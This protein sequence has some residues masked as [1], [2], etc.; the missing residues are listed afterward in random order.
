MVVIVIAVM[1]AI[2][3]LFG[4][5]LFKTS[6]PEIETAKRRAGRQGEQFAAQ[7]IKEIL[8][9][10]DVLLTNVKVSVEGKNA[11]LDSVIIN[12]CGIFIIEVKNYT[13]V[14]CGNEDDHEWIQTAGSLSGY[15][16]QKTVRNPVKQVKRQIKVLSDYLKQYGMDIRIKGYAFFV[17]GNSPIE[18]GYI[19]KT[20]K[21]I[22]AAAHLANNQDLTDDMKRK[23]VELLSE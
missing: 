12:N 11:E 7:L 13:G 6:L 23:I 1:I 21:D 22:D 8:D 14:L 5:L 3:V 15:P 18:S 2:F 4:L 9:D 16:Y 20:Q 10:K 19:L 17:E